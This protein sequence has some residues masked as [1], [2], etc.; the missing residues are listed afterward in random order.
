[1]RH[2]DFWAGL[3]GAGASLLITL[4]VLLAI[5]LV[6]RSFSRLWRWFTSPRIRPTVLSKTSDEEKKPLAS[7]PDGFFAPDKA[8]TK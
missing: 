6:E 8:D 2:D 7:A 1:M 3:L 5:L 4:P